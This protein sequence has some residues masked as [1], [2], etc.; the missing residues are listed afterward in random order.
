[1]TDPDTSAE[2]FP[3]DNSSIPFEMQFVI[4]KIESNDS[5]ENEENVT[6]TKKTKTCQMTIEMQVADSN[7]MIKLP[8]KV[9]R[10]WE[11]KQTSDN[12]ADQISMITG[13]PKQEIV[14]AAIII[15]ANF[16]KKD[17]DVMDKILNENKPIKKR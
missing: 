9:F 10:S 12:L 17:P 1:M 14:S 16:L 4:K 8:E 15:A 5:G 11:I 13:H 6:K 3:F 7:K 2:G